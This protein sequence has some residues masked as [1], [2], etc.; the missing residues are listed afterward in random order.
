MVTILTKQSI[1]YNKK[2]CYLLIGSWKSEEH[3]VSISAT[4]DLQAPT[5]A[6]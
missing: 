3:A 5:A 2:I 4:L 6:H 1:K